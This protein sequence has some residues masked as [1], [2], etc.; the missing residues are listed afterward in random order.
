MPAAAQ[1]AIEKQCCRQRAVDGAVQCWAH[2]RAGG[3]CPRWVRP[4]EGEP[5]PIPYC[6]QHLES[7]D[8]A[9]KVVE[10]PK[11]KQLGKILV[12][13][14]DLPAGYQMCF[15]GDR[16]ACPWVFEDDRTL[17]YKSGKARRHPNG[18]IDPSKRLGSLLQVG[19]RLLYLPAADSSTASLTG[20]TAP[21]SRRR[22]QFMS[23]PGV[24]EVQTV[25]S[26]SGPGAYFGKHCGN[27]VGQR[28]K[29]AMPIPK[30][31]QLAF[32]YGAEWFKIRGLP[33]LSIGTERYPVP[34][35]RVPTGEAAVAGAASRLVHRWA[36]ERVR[37]EQLEPLLQ[38]L[39]QP[40]GPEA[41]GPTALVELGCSAGRTG[42]IVAA[43]AAD[44]G[45]RWHRRCRF[46]GVDS[47]DAIR[48]IAASPHGKQR[49][50]ASGGRLSFLSASGLYRLAGLAD[51]SVDVVLGR[52]ALDTLLRLVVPPLVDPAAVAK[53]AK[54]AKDA[55]AGGGTRKAAS[56][57]E[58]AKK[59]KK[60]GA[61][62]KKAA[63][64]R[65]RVRR[66]RG[67]TVILLSLTPPRCK[68]IIPSSQIPRNHSTS[69]AQD[70]RRRGM[71]CAAE[72]SRVLRPGG[73]V[74]VESFTTPTEDPSLGWLAAILP[75]LDWA[76]VGF[77]A[78]A[79]LRF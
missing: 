31:T 74:V 62:T 15:W 55:K 37:W 71:E 7:G 59:K 23:S 24:E 47:P 19:A 56:K 26:C 17:Q 57:A 29:T 70:G 2:S 43:A 18:V 51:G 54:D 79:A 41:S 68:Y 40:D 61:Q 53:E 36:A 75:A 77:A 21:R 28:C 22:A 12:A 16:A 46:Y 38:P 3:R 64:A 32:Q 45:A 27:L 30:D 6:E 42:G 10:H 52:Q 48:Q 58:A 66:R 67:S 39:L 25:A 5:L 76:E 50:A 78:A 4:R 65:Q 49:L 13:R 8:G 69:S 9:F 72:L 63:A 44:T 14:F 35:R 11:I 73:A 60:R 34:T 1:P 33:R 20:A